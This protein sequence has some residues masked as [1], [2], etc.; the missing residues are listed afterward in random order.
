MLS[1]TS[2]R[3]PFRLIRHCFLYMNII[4]PFR[5]SISWAGYISTSTP[6]AKGRHNIGVW[7]QTLEAFDK[8][9]SMKPGDLAGNSLKQTRRSSAMLIIDSSPTR[10]W[11]A[12]SRGTFSLGSI[13][14]LITH[15]A[16]MPDDPFWKMLIDNKGWKYI[17]CTFNYLWWISNFKLFDLNWLPKK[18]NFKKFHYK[19]IYL[20]EFRMLTCF[21]WAK[22]FF[23]A[24]GL[25]VFLLNFILSEES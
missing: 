24:W 3:C 21:C 6:Q 18:C 5:I 12:R 23:P 9:P 15:P 11:P 10:M 8:P 1:L 7:M 4:C 14:D 20:F 22:T 2:F 13:I 16:R 19:W 25:Q 17:T